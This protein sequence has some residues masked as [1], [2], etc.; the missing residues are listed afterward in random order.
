[1]T[2]AQEPILPEQVRVVPATPCGDPGAESTSGLVAYVDGEVFEDAG[3]HE[4]SHPTPRRV[5]M[6]TDFPR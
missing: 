4:V 2:R 1:M 3:F 5:V 6:R